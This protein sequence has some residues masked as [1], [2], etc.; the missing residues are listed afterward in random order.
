L[1]HFTYFC[2]NMSF[3]ILHVS[4]LN[5]D[6]GDEINNSW[7]L[8]SLEND[9]RQFETQT[10]PIQK[11]SLCIVSGDLIYGVRAGTAN[12]DDELKRQYAQAEEFLIGLAERFFDGN[13][14][15]VVILPGN[16]DVSFDDVRR[17]A[18]KIAELETLISVK[19]EIGE[20]RPD[21]VFYARSLPRTVWDRPWMAPI[22]RVVLV[23]RLREVNSTRQRSGPG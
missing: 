3:S 4:D 6:L 15:R 14:E 1:D 5:R 12:A 7:L 17:I 22:E 8:D 13:R 9:F 11:P 2:Q 23:H 18:A 20:D 21:G 19:D 16:H 10:P